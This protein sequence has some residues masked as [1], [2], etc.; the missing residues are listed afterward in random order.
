MDEQCNAKTTCSKL[1][2]TQHCAVGSNG[3]EYCSC[4]Q[5]FVLDSDN[6]TCNDID[7]CA[8]NP[9][10]ENCTQT[11]PGPGY[12][13]TCE[14][15]KMLDVDNRTCIDCKDGFYGKECSEKCI[16][17]PENTKTCG[18]VS[19]ICTCRAGWNGTDCSVDVDECKNFANICPD[20]SD[21]TNL[22]G[23]YLCTCK[24]GFSMSNNKCTECSLMAFGE[25]CASQ[26]T[27]DF[28]NAWSCDKRNGT[29]YCRDGWQ[30]VNCKVDVQECSLKPNK[31]MQD[32]SKLIIGLGI[33]IPLF[34]ALIAIAIII[35]VHWKRSARKNNLDDSDSDRSPEGSEIFRSR[36]PVRYGGWGPLYSPW[37]QKSDSKFESSYLG[38]G[39]N[40]Q[41]GWYQED[42]IPEDKQTDEFSWDF[43]RS[44]KPKDLT[45]EIKRPVADSLPNPLYTSLQSNIDDVTV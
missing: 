34:L 20:N 26:C 33:G 31:I 2:C 12:T 41:D 21:C 17:K 30:G 36:L 23:T 43:M 14:A 42:S 25:N 28:N 27:C 9:C 44:M 29:C 13:C 7:E 37:G 11:T 32:H 45:F 38:P 10:D 3:Q 22:N 19:G 4:Y 35:I 18:N 6:I 8:S 15:G 40:T 5:G 39:Q 1:N 16:C 24:D